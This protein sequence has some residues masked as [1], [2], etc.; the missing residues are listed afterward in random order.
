[1][2]FCLE[3]SNYKNLSKW[4]IFSQQTALGKGSKRKPAAFR[5]E[6]YKGDDCWGGRD[7]FREIEN[8]E[9][10][11]FLLLMFLYPNKSLG[12]LLDSDFFMGKVSPKSEK[13]VE[14]CFN[15]WSLG[16]GS[17]AQQHLNC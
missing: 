2:S 11:K 12:Q 9:I 5:Q 16:D 1:M 6:A 14:S 10:G 17:F 4:S 7:F 3:D 15:K 13:L 8:W